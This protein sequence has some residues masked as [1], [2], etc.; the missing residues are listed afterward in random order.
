M[1]LS[2]QVINVVSM[3]TLYWLSALIPLLMMPIVLPM[4][5]LMA[6]KKRMTDAPN[7]RKL[8][9]QPVVVMGGMVIVSIICTTLLIINIFYSLDAL[10]PLLCMILV[11][12]TFGMLDD[13]IGLSWQFKLVMQIAAVLLFYVAGSYGVHSLH[14]L[15]GIEDVPYWPSMFI[16]LFVGLLL[17]NAVNF[18]DGIDGLASGLGAMAAYIMSFWN[19]YHGYV[20]QA[21]LS[22]AMAST[23]TLFF[24]YNVF[25]VKYKTY[26]GDS[27]SLAVGLFVYIS[28]C[29]TTYNTVGTGMLVDRY[30]ITFIVALLSAMIFDLIRVVIFRIMRGKSPFEPDRTHLHHIYVDLGMSHFMAT[31]IILISNAFVIAVWFWTAYYG[32]D[33]TLQFFFVIL[34]GIIVFWTPVMRMNYLVNKKPAKYDRIRSR[35]LKISNALEPV[36][37]IIN[38]I[39]D[40]RRVVSL[41]HDKQ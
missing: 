3:S 13:N 15:F 26:M 28:S 4:V 18:I 37:T 6:K 36:Y 41:S 30:F 22:L 8:Q 19:I 32:M 39:I 34:V 16:T 25:S 9:K 35:T 5:V 27:G 20:D 7:A 21:V 12:Y 11:I 1:E 38:K 2:E 24:V 31:T 14:G 40:R 33:I 10:F 29:P 23:L 17:F